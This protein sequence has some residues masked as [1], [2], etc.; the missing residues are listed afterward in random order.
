[1]IIVSPQLYNKEL[2][3]EF[4][5]FEDWV[6]TY[7]LFRGKASEEDG[8]SDER[9]VGKFKVSGFIVLHAFWSTLRWYVWSNSLRP[10]AGK[11]LLVQTDR[12]WRRSLG[13][14]RQYGPLSGQQRDP[15][16]QLSSSSHTGLRCLSASSFLQIKS[17][18]LK[19]GSLWPSRS[20]PPKKMLL[21]VLRS[22][23][24]LFCTSGYLNHPIYKGKG[25]EKA[26]YSSSAGIE[27]APSW[28]GWESGPLHCASA[29]QE[30]NQR[31]R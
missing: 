27:L 11:I 30:W 6:K 17:F 1:M 18:L 2:E 9:F 8:T 16:K 26:F 29:W 24:I 13:W 12:R 10:H 23:C 19:L 14:P 5:Y 25:Q 15:I 31:Q 21:D 28:P 3:R 4:G 7:E 22:C 20:S